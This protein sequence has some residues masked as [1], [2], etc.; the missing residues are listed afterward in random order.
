MSGA[1]DV[2]TSDARVREI[3][4]EIADAGELFFDLEFVS[5]ARLVPELALVQVAWGDVVTPEVAILDCLAVDPAPIFE[6]IEDEAMPTVAHAAIQDLGLLA[7][8]FDVHARHFWDT[9]VA[10]AFCG[11]GDQIGYGGL[12]KSLVGVELDKGAQFTAWLERPLSERQLAYARSDVFYLPRAWRELEQRLEARGRLSWVEA[13]CQ[14]VAAGATGLPEPQEAFRSLKGWKGLDP[15]QLGALRALAAWRQETAVAKNKPLSWVLPERAMIELCRRRA[16]S[17]R[18]LESVRGVGPGTVRRYG[19]DI[20]EAMARGAVE[21]VEA[22]RPRRGGEPSSRGQLW[23]QIVLGIVQSRCAEAEIAP[24]FVGT[25]AD[26]EALVGWFEAGAED[27][28][29]LALLRGWRREMVG[30]D[31]LAWLRGEKAVVAS[32]DGAGAITLK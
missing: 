2:V 26:A 3:A 5:E 19:A 29:D 10:A 9:Q 13:E 11:V 31:L 8:R 22:P 20:L 18:D 12:I 25:R 17:P 6:M 32:T 7:T 24:R 30:D 16:R 23:T 27:D 4:R 15:R 21:P 1:D 28:P 14:D